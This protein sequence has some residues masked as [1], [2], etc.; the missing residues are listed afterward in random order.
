MAFRVELTHQASH[1]AEIILEWLQSQHAGDA[2]LRWF[3]KL[4]RAIRS[5]ALMPGRCRLAP[6]NEAVP[7]EMRQLLYGHRSHTYRILF[8]IDRDVVMIL[9]IRHGKRRHLNE[10]H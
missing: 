4:N 5:L 3:D 1:D 6:E 10:P 9:P 7:F 2:G 8:T